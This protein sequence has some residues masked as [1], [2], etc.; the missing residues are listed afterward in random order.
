MVSG[1]TC[2]SNSVDIAIRI[3]WDIIIINV[4]HTGNVEAPCGHVGC[5]QDIQVPV[6]EFLHDLR[7]SVLGEVTMNSG[8]VVPPGNQSL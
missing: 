2:P 4:G 6:L 5:N 7:A 1:P 3:G 8:G